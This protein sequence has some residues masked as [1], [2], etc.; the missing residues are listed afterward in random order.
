MTT[1]SIQSRVRKITGLSVL[2]FG[3]AVLSV[4]CG[5]KKQEG[6]D[7]PA[8][9]PSQ[10]AARVNGTE[11]TVHQIDQELRRMGVP[12]DTKPEILQE[13][14]NNILTR[15]INDQ[16]VINKAIEQG[17]DRKPEVV[18]QIERAKREIITRAYVTQLVTSVSKPTEQEL[19]DFFMKNEAAY[20][21]NVRYAVRRL[22]IRFEPA[23]AEVLQAQLARNPPVS[24]LSRWLT[25]NQIPAMQQTDIVDTASLPQ[26]TRAQMMNLKPRQ[27]IA[28][29]GNGQAVV[30]EIL[31]AE[32]YPITRADLDPVAVN[33]LTGDRRNEII[34]SNV[35]TMREGAKIEYMSGFAQS[36]TPEQ[37]QEL[38]N[39]LSG[40][41]APA[42]APAAPAAQ[43]TTPA[44]APTAP[45]VPAAQEAAP[46]AVAPAP[47]AVSPAKP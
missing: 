7:A 20:K 30:M 4:G 21:E 17:V 26:E 44:A 42:A 12:A 37:F 3:V 27:V 15:L 39:K 2:L 13:I 24:E 23:Q 35:K 31:R 9:K 47:A 32:A 45:V 8:D 6:S 5:D 40:E 1:Q 16:L 29:V 38:V 34:E 41:Q 25:Q 43:E 10:V 19:N 11:I 22:M 14:K 33:Q 18:E 36:K 28:Q 46:A